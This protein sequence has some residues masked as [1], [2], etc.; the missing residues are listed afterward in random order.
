MNRKNLTTIEEDEDED[1]D[2][3]EVLK[4]GAERDV[5]DFEDE[6][7]GCDE[8]DIEDDRSESEEL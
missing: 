2:E 5:F 6:E 8:D 7:D 4:R 1:E 3:D